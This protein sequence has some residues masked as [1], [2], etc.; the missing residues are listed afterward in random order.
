MNKHLH[1]LM[2]KLEDRFDMESEEYFKLPEKTKVEL[3]NLVIEYYLPVLRNSEQALVNLILAYGFKLEEAVQQEDF[4]QADM[5]KRIL[6]T[7]EEI[8]RIND[9]DWNQE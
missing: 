9:K 5:C 1:E 3:T 4:E 7:L 2:L 8:N 6:K